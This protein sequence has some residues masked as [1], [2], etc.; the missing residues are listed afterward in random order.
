MFDM[1]INTAW[2]IYV[3]YLAYT[4]FIPSW[5][6]ARYFGFSYFL[7]QATIG[8]IYLSIIVEGIALF[9]R[10][11]EWSAWVDISIG[12]FVFLLTSI[13]YYIGKQREKFNGKIFLLMLGSAVPPFFVA[14]IKLLN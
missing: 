5:G 8:L 14:I 1:A 6:Q 13:V 12:I 4:A 3:V 9:G 10:L 2:M 7:F 11:L